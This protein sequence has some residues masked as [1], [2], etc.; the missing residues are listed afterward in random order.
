VKRRDG[1]TRARCPLQM[2]V[3]D[4]LE[5]TVG[6]GPRD[7]ATSPTEP[8]SFP[9]P[10]LRVPEMREFNGML[11][12]SPANTCPLVDH[13][14]PPY[15]L[16]HVHMNLGTSQLANSNADT[17]GLLAARSR[18]LLPPVFQRSK[19]RNLAN[20]RS[21]W[22]IPWVFS[23]ETPMHDPTCR[24]NGCPLLNQQSRSVLLLIRR[25]TPLTSLTSSAL[26]LA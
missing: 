7:L 22:P 21:S 23:Y 17:L 11:T 2:D 12:L 16:P 13:A 5:N 25:L 18:G 3:P 14:V 6:P 1:S 20:L 24:S 15:A 4:Q 9:P 8:S 19:S 10:I 26:Y